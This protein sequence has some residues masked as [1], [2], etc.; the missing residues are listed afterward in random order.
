MA[1]NLQNLRRDRQQ[2]AI[3]LLLS[4]ERIEVLRIEML[5]NARIIFLFRV[6]LRRR[7]FMLVSHQQLAFQAGEDVRLPLMK[8]I[9]KV[10]Q[11]IRR[12]GALQAFFDKLLPIPAFLIELVRRN[13]HG[14][15]CS[16][17]HW[18]CCHLRFRPQFPDKNTW[19][20]SLYGPSARFAFFSSQI[21]SRR[22]QTARG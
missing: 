12:S 18:T 4:S 16:S 19:C 8:E 13:K 22:C 5:H 20:A 21:S 3:R 1:A 17:T 14:K 10:F 6:R 15:C 9:H 7:H 11:L 2:S